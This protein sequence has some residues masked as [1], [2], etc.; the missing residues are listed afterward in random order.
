MTDSRASLGARKG[1]AAVAL[2]LALVAAPVGLLGLPGQATGQ[3]KP[4][5]PVKDY[6]KWESLSGRPALSPDGRW[7]AYRLVRVN[8][9]S[10]LRVKS[11]APEGVDAATSD[12]DAERVFVWGTGPVFSADSRWL[13]WSAGVS[14]EERERLAEEDE[15]VRLGAGLL[16]LSGGEERSFDEVADFGF[17][18]SGR[19]LAL[20]GYAPEEPEEPEGPEGKGA[21]L[22]LVDLE[23]GAE[24][25]FGNVAEYAW[26]ETGSLLA[27]AVA[28]GSDQGNGVQ[29]YDARSSRLQGHDSSSSTYRQLS[30]REVDDEQ[31]EGSATGGRSSADLALLRTVEPASKDGT[32][33]HVLV[34]R[35][36]D[37]DGSRP[38][39]LDPAAVAGVAADLEVVRHAQP[40]W[41]DDGRRVGIGLRPAD[42]EEERAEAEDVEAEVEE[43]GNPPPPDPDAGGEDEQGNT[44]GA[45]EEEEEVEL[46]DLQ[47]WHTADVRL[48]PEQSAAEQ[49]DAQRTLLAVWHLDEDRVVQIGSDF[50]E[51]AELIEGGRYAIEQ[52]EVPYPWGRM[53]GRRYH[54]V[55]VVDVATGVRRLALERV[56]Y[57]WPS[58]GGRYLLHFDCEDYWSYDVDSAELTNITADLSADFADLDHD[59]PTDLLPPH[60]IGGWVVDD[61]AV[62]LY[63]HHDVW[64]VSPTGTA[65]VRLTDGA[66]EAVVHRVVDLDPDEEPIDPSQPLYLSLHGEWSEQ[67]GYA[68]TIPGQLGATRGQTVERLIL[69][70]KMVGGLRVADDA[71]VFI[72]RAEA[73][74]DSPDYFVAG[75]DL[76]APRQ[77]TQTNRF[78]DDYAWSRSALVEFES[79]TGRR[80]QAALL[81]PANHDPSR[82]Y[83]MIV[84][85]YEILS[86]GVHRYGPPSERDYYSFTAWT[87]H[88]YFVLLPDIVY[89]ARD[90]GVSALEAVRPAV[91]RTVDMGLVD[92]DR[93]GLIGH[94]WGG[95]QAT[96]LPTRTDIF[97]A[98]VAGAPLTDFVSFMGA[99]HW[100]RGIAEVDHWETGQARMEVPFW[101]DPE[102]HRRN[103]PIHEVHRLE[104]P[105]LMAFGDNDGVVDWDQGTEF[106]NFAR[107][108]GKQMVLLVYEGEDHGFRDE[109]NQVDYHRRILEWFGHYLKDEPAPRW[110]TEGIPIDELEDEQRRVAQAGGKEEGEPAQTLPPL[111]PDP[112]TRP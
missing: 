13:V 45:E 46:P 84:Y 5:V 41:S 14:E 75:P 27:L 39:V 93:V 42:T 29:L 81:Y 102:A 40:Q 94:S 66:D 80:L 107:R 91:A 2:T 88:G 64:M 43:D 34:W 73:H 16:E 67:R 111:S 99:I 8:E 12:V 110:I 49:R 36:L 23:T 74:D 109:P 52:V 96:Y 62:L 30:W 3:Q 32:A 61:A 55:W 100:N 83:P 15:T 17:D 72:Y 37:S 69:V 48:F 112:P 57:S 11:L 105:L 24:T 89:R 68:R 21:D 38:V 50:M 6:G 71:D 77:V 63:D 22:R 106:Y 47:I 44:D 97:A 54:D 70:D 1:P 65:A 51:R 108:A 92:A 87:Q 90:P 9:E 79:E 20:H 104:T 82:R 56:R 60:G 28:T 101:E 18:E 25:T 31:R 76:L 19:F 59:V 85:T 53:F 103:S 26:S 86:S 35:G 58:A 33:H 95:Y 4:T 98:S 7:L 10:E 78:Q